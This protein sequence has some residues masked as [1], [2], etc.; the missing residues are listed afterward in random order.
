M[1]LYSRLSRGIQVTTI[2]RGLETKNK[3][4]YLISQLPTEE[5]INEI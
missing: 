4:S 1:D 3:K 2:K 5:M